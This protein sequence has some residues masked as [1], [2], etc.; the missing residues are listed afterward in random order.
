[1]IV[2]RELRVIVRC[3]RGSARQEVTNGMDPPDRDLQSPHEP[4][5]RRRSRERRP[6]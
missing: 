1:M 6:G 4:Q 3:S 2:D 5:R